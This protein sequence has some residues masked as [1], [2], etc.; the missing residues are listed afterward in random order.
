VRV[1]KP[2]LAITTPIGMAAGLREAWRFH[3]W[4]A[5]LMAGL[6]IVIAAFFL[7][8]LRR[9][10]SEGATPPEQADKRVDAQAQATGEGRD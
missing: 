1:A 10:R 4:L 6:M 7:M 5:V 9:I 2:L 3:W 8:T